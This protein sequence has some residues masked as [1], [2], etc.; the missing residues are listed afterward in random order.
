LIYIL[1]I[2]LHPFSTRVIA[3][4]VALPEA[5]DAATDAEAAAVP[6]LVKAIVIADRRQAW[7]DKGYIALQHLKQLRQLADAALPEQ[8]S[9]FRNSRGI[10]HLKYQTGN[11]VSNVQVQRS[12]PT[13][14]ATKELIRNLILP[15]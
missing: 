9:R 5:G 12:L 2:Q 14:S 11:C 10:S 15:R 13:P 4:A 3:A 7:A 1:H 8:L 6:V